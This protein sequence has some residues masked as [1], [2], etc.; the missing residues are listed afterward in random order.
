MDKYGL[1]AITL[2]TSKFNPMYHA[3]TTHKE[4]VVMKM[5]CVGED[6]KVR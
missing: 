6:E 2:Y 5:I 4:Q 3:V 1:D